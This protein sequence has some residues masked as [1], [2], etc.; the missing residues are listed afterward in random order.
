MFK[1]G[2]QLLKVVQQRLVKVAQRVLFKMVLNIYVQ[3]CSTND[4][5]GWFVLWSRMFKGVVK[6][7]PADVV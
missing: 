5:Q 1:T 3:G 7:C 4:F 6:G 2:H